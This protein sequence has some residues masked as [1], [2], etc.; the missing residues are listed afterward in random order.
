MSV[1][2]RLPYLLKRNAEYCLLRKKS[3]G[4][5]SRLFP[6]AGKKIV[7][8]SES[9]RSSLRIQEPS[10]LTEMLRAY[11]VVS[12]DIFD[13]LILRNIERPEDVFYFE[14]GRLN[15]PNLKRL[16]TEAERRSRENRY[17]L[18]GDCE[19]NFKEIWD[20]LSEMTGID[21][22]TGMECEWDIEKIVCYA[23][24]YFTEVIRL[25]KN[26]GKKLVVCSDMYL[27][28]KYI[29]ELLLDKNYPEFDGYFISS[30]YR[31]SKRDG[32]LFAVI[33]KRYGKELRY[34]HVGDNEYSDVKMA[35][36]KGFKTILYPNVQRAGLPYRA[37]DMDPVLASVY[38]G[39]INGYLNC[40]IRKE[41]P[42]FEFGFIYGGLFAAGY[43]RFI[44]DYVKEHSIDKVIFFSRDGDILQKVYTLLF[45]EEAEKTEYAYWSRL[46]AAKMSA[47]LLKALFFERMLIHKTGQGYRLNEIFETMELSSMQNRFFR[48][49]S[50][51]NYSPSSAFDEKACRDLSAFLDK[52]WAEV[53]SQ[54]DDELDEGRKYYQRI[55][56]NAE[57]AAVVDVGW[58]GS[59][60]IALERIAKEIWG[61]RCEFFGLLAGSCSANTFDYESTLMNI[62]EGK[63]N[64][65][66]FSPKDNR[67]LWKI[68]DPRKGH[69][70][71]IELLLSSPEKSFRGF[72]KG[73]G[74]EYSFSDTHERINAREVQRGI[75]K[76]AE[77]LKEHPFRQL[78]I[79]GRDAAAP[80][81][82][83]Y[84]NPRYINELLRQSEIHPNIE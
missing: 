17:R 43:C 12:F 55:L 65:Y 60:A 31:K 6:D 83:L 82:L 40:G 48:E 23:N 39:I 42:E 64:C 36:G 44:K 1:Y 4:D 3:T 9:S 63:L 77:L 34:I 22:E 57:R 80:I 20:V 68:H 25:L 76:F 28:E 56:G 32:E 59:G 7:M 2:K 11:D 41:S 61:F 37:K 35:A 46:A 33:Q 81:F 18:A 47:R 70:M 71:V 50:H 5:D 52:H 49:C 19:V 26:S 72:S 67:D 51:K 62:E 24:P 79:S 21:P 38:A 8:G 14:Q 45:P 75:L 15:Y 10:R 58:V 69:N 84:N 54:Y 16:R 30:D 66:L 53:C 29:R 13:T 78:K 73:P 27:G 74:G